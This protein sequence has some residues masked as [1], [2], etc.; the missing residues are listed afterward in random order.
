MFGFRARYAAREVADANTAQAITL[1]RFLA[2]HY[3]QAMAAREALLY[4][5]L[6]SRGAQFAA[7]HCRPAQHF[8]NL[9]V[10]QRAG[11][12]LALENRADQP[13]ELSDPN[14]VFTVASLLGPG[15]DVQLP[16]WDRPK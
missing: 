14:T 6:V 13:E 3:P 7:L 10:A 12:D 4:A 2:E 5:H 8:G 9:K 15:Q 11:P 16:G 1:L